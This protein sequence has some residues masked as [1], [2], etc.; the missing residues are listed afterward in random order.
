LLG[1]TVRLDGAAD[2]R[3]AIRG[4]ENVVRASAGHAGTVGALVVSGVVLPR[5][6]GTDGYG[7]YAGLLAL[8]AILQALSALGLPQVQ[9][10]YLSPVARA[11]GS[12]DALS[13][14]S[15][16]WTVR[17]GLSAVAGL[18]AVAWLWKTKGELLA[19]T[20][21]PLVGLVCFLRAVQETHRSFFLS[22][23]R[24]G[25][26]AALRFLEVLL[27]VP[28]VAS[29]YWMWHLAGAFNAL[30]VLYG[31]LALATAIAL[32]RLL[33]VSFRRF[34]WRALEPHCLYGLA[35]FVAS[36]LAVV[37]AQYGI[38]AVAHRVSAVE[39]G[40]LAVALQL[41]VLPRGVFLSGRLS[42]VPLLAE[43]DAAGDL[44]RLRRWAET[45]VRYSVAVLSAS[46]LLWRGLGDCL[47]ELL[48]GKEFRSVHETA[49]LLLLGLVFYCAGAVP[50]ALLAVRERA[51]WAAVLALAYTTILLGGLEV[52]I[53][54]GGGRLLTRISLVY[55]GSSLVFSIGAFL[56]LGAAAHLWIPVRR[57]LF[58]ALP[59]VLSFPSVPWP[60][61]IE[62]RLGVLA[63]VLG[64]YLA[65]SIRFRLLP[66][67]ELH[68]AVTVLRGRHPKPI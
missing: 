24:V 26:H 45:I 29:G 34:R 49:G 10:R 13:L 56:L 38:L 60:A 54:S 25:T 50:S 37:Q 61:A 16:I 27:T 57:V 17:V 4:V 39:A 9:L 65:A 53:G 14:G 3:R 41:F 23:G 68:F 22:L 30:V 11:R 7:R 35:S 58:L 21:I 8:L 59:C 2:D 62:A 46:C 12:E 19:P 32:R 1:R 5:V 51:V 40:I 63:L 66:W 43:I 48:W 15:S 64:L 6:M 18:L 33:P 42:L 67:T 31:T 28:L 44:T 52:V 55:V 47:V 36:V 20:L